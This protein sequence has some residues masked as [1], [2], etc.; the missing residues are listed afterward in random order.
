MVKARIANLGDSVLTLSP[1]EFGQL[2]VADT[3]NWAKVIK[4][5]NIKPE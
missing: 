3:E 4:L 5:A 2:A 1:A